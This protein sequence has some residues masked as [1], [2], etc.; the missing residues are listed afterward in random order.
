MFGKNCKRLAECHKSGG[1]GESGV[2]EATDDSRANDSTDQE[3]AD[4]PATQSAEDKAKDILKKG[5]IN[6]PLTIGFCV[7]CFALVAGY[8]WLSYRIRHGEV[9]YSSVLPWAQFATAMSAA[10]SALSDWTIRDRNN[11]I[12][13]NAPTGEEKVIKKTSHY[14]IALAIC[15]LARALFILVGLIAALIV[16]Q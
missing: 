3:S 14:K 10:L 2:D 5:Y 6:L 12:E 13:I 8:A 11:A 9:L 7:V 15:E 1:T 16:L 4:K